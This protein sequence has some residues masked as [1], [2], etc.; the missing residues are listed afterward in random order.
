MDMVILTGRVSEEELAEE[1][2]AEYARLRETLRDA[3]PPS[4]RAWWIGRIV[5]T[6][7]VLLGL[8]V[9]TLVLYAVASG[10]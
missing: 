9:V 1:R 5:G 3:G 8:T 7:A 4:R 10:Q 6:A 2:A